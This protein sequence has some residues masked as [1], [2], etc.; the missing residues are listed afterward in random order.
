[1]NTFPKAGQ[2]LRSLARAHS[3]R[4]LI[5]IIIEVLIGFGCLV[6]EN[7]LD[8]SERFLGLLRFWLEILSPK[9]LIEPLNGW[10]LEEFKEASLKKSPSTLS[11]SKTELESFFCTK[12]KFTSSITL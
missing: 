1:M 2:H 10:I 11:T 8:I 7:S 6:E 12:L 5:L 9:S 3:I 4:S